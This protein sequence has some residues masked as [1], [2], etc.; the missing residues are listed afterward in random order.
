[1]LTRVLGLWCGGLPG[2]CDLD[3]RLT[4]LVLC[5]GAQ[6]S[7]QET[8]KMTK[9]TIHR[10]KNFDDDDDDNDDDLL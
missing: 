5:C 9:L 6:V 1:V 4:C 8:K 10:R 2:A 7:T 3:R